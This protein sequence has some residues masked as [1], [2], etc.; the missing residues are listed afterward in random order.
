MTHVHISTAG[1]T[2]AP[3]QVHRLQARAT[4]AAANVLDRGR[5]SVSVLVTRA[6]VNGW[7]IEG[8]PVHLAAH[9]Q[10]RITG[11]P[12][13]A[14]QRIC[15]VAELQDLL[16]LVFGPVMPDATL[17]VV[18]DASDHAG[19]DVTPGSPSTASVRV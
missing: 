9:V 16:R 10:V 2:L 19:L 8:R 17:V 5:R 1:P 14:G 4:E 6:P 12:T 18:D 3:E 7:S 15:L 13:T 11:A